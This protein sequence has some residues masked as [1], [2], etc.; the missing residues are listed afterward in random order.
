MISRSLILQILQAA[1]IMRNY[2]TNEEK[3]FKGSA[4]GPKLSFVSGQQ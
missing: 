3:S 2:T 4:I 1:K